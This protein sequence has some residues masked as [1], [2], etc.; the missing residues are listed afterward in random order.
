MP[1][2]FC[3]LAAAAACAIKHARKKKKRGLITVVVAPEKQVINPLQTMRENMKTNN[4]GAAAAVTARR[5]IL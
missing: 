2:L 3:F 1:R 4:V 5:I